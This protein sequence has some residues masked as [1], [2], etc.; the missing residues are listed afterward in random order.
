MQ[1]PLLIFKDLLDQLAFLVDRKKMRDGFRCV[2]VLAAPF[3]TRGL[4]SCFESCKCQAG[5]ALLMRQLRT[6]I[7]HKAKKIACMLAADQERTLFSLWVGRSRLEDPRIRRLHHK[8]F[9]WTRTTCVSTQRKAFFPKEVARAEQLHDSSPEPERGVGSKCANISTLLG[10]LP[11]RGS[12]AARAR[13]PRLM[14]QLL[15]CSCLKLCPVPTQP[16]VH[17]SR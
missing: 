17:C 2:L 11:M 5:G 12:R 16:L 10:D 6:A 1:V 15:P 9:S 8:V 4:L 3:L 7:I 14:V 13:D